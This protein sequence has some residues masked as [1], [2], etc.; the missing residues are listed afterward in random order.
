MGFISLMGKPR[1][2][3]EGLVPDALDGKLRSP[4]EH[5]QCRGRGHVPPVPLGQLLP[6][7]VGLGDSG[8]PLSLTPRR[9]SLNVAGRKGAC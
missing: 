3:E 2:R 7:G 1:H 8:E 6:G 5:E 9:L 4:L